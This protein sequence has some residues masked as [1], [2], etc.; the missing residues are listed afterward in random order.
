LYD[1]NPKGLS[2]QNDK[3]KVWIGVGPYKLTA[4]MVRGNKF[5][6]IGDGK[7]AITDGKG[8]DGKKCYPLSV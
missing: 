3:V 2:T 8:H 4:V 6:V 1:C 7:V 5:E